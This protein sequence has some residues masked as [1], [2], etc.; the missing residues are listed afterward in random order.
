MATVKIPEQ[1]KTDVPMTLFGRILL[2]TPVVMAV[3]ATLLAGL[4]S[5]E[6]TRA[7]YD[8]A[9]GAQLQSKAGDQWSFFQAK[10]L[11]S[12]TQ[13]NTVDLLEA[14][15][16]LGL[17]STES[18]TLTIGQLETYLQQVDAQ[19]RKDLQ[20]PAVGQGDVLNRYLKDAPRRN[21][22]AQKIQTALQTALQSPEAA[23][24]IPAMLQAQVPDIGSDATLTRE[25]ADAI[26]V[27]E[28]STSESEI[29]AAISKLKDAAIADALRS[30]K[31]R[32]TTLDAA[33][34]PITQCIDRI[35]KLLEQGASLL[36][37]TR[38]IAPHPAVPAPWLLREFAAARMRYSV[39]RYDAEARLNQAIANLLELQVRR[40]NLSAERH[41]FRSQRFFYGMLGAQL[42]VIVSAFSV[43]A[44]KRNLLWTLAAG[45]GLLAVLF[46]AYVYLYL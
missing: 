10:K 16:D 13:R 14:S 29:T 27:L 7:Q 12:A 46:G 44:R 23:K 11:R 9:L 21:A 45:A 25:I 24:A 20:A 38:E 17:L 28:N 22:Q 30:A 33:T 8:R 43:A 2:T 19:A 15:G 4:A 36:K 39:A 5:S 1:L 31:N 35:E 42:A 41:H 40:A 37:E 3:V 18:L 6:M 26:E 32:P 34:K